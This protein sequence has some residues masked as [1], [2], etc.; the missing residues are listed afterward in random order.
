MFLGYFPK[1]FKTVVRSLNDGLNAAFAKTVRNQRSTRGRASRRNIF[2][3]NFLRFRKKKNFFFRPD[4]NDVRKSG[5]RWSTIALRTSLRYLKDAYS[6]NNNILDIKTKNDF[7]KVCTY[8]GRWQHL[9]NGWKAKVLS[10]KKAS[11]RHPTSK[12]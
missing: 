2:P 12:K 11:Q 4:N 1:V 10:D 9:Q 6:G 8:S 7:Q 3:P 5:K